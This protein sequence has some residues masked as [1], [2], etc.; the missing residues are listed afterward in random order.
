[1]AMY[2]L[3]EQDQIDDLKAWWTRYGG[4]V[5]VA[6]VLG[7]LV[8][9]GIQGWRWYTGKRAENASVLYSAVSEAVRTKDTAKAKDAIAEITDRYASTGYAPR[10][11][12]LYAKMLYDAGDRNGA[13]AQLT[14]VVDH[15]P[16][17]ELQSIARYRLAQVQ[18]DEKQYDAALATLDAKHPA[19]FDGL[20]AD[21]RGDALAAAGRAA[22]ARS[23]Y[24]TALAKLDSKS[25][26]RNY[27]QVKRDALAPATTPASTSASATTPA[28]A[29]AT[30]PASTATRTTTPAS[31][32]TSATTP[33]PAPAQATTPAPTATRTTTPSQTTAPAPAASDG[34]A[35]VRDA[36]VKGGAAK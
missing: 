33:A 16:E 11:E 26:Y 21:L 1:M 8:I 2:D 18:V 23:A 25:A 7:C 22:D 32:P 30:T 31:A 35:P 5:T 15:S 20:Y 6:L 3:D 14:W 13:K 27:V 17:E 19:S 34:D 36:P 9:A 10:A 29:Q 24:E 12:L 4:T 28:P